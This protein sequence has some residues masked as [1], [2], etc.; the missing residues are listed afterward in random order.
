MIQKCEYLSLQEQSCGIV[1]KYFGSYS[2]GSPRKPQTFLSIDTVE[3]NYG[4]CN[5]YLSI[6]SWVYNYLHDGIGKN[7]VLKRVKR[8]YLPKLHDAYIK[9]YDCIMVQLDDHYDM[10]NNGVLRQIARCTDK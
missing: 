2:L 5:F 7:R 6:Q 8:S 3:Q 1:N 4:F 9:I 10:D